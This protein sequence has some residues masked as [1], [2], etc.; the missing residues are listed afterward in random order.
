[1]NLLDPKTTVAVFSTIVFLIMRWRWDY[2]VELYKQP[3][4]AIK[5]LLIWVLL[6]LLILRILWQIKPSYFA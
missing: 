2:I 4:M 5:Y 3:K 1:M 6:L